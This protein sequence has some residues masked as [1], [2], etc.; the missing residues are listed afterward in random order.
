M[1][2]EQNERGVSDLQVRHLIDK[3][4]PRLGL[5]DWQITVT[6]QPTDPH[7]YAHLGRMTDTYRAKITINADFY[8]QSQIDVP[9]LERTVVHE[10]LHISMCHYASSVEDMIDNVV[11]GREG[12]ALSRQYRTEEE[13]FVDRMALALVKEWSNE[14]SIHGGADTE[15]QQDDAVP[16]SHHT[17]GAD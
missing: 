8:T 1:G 17:V 15:R 12:E 16:G 13:R 10:L 7:E 14:D 3:W 2:M 9:H 4:V 6:V 5:S 11:G